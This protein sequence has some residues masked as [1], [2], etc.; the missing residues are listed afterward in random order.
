MQ[1]EIM[2][3]TAVDSDYPRIARLLHTPAVAFIV[4]GMPAEAAAPFMHEN[5]QGCGNRPGHR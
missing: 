5:D 4:P 2:I 1:Q 3:R